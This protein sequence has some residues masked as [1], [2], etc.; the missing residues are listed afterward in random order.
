MSAPLFFMS[1]FY[2][3]PEKNPIHQ[4][5]KIYTAYQPEVDIDKTL[6]KVRGKSVC[7]IFKLQ[8]Q[9]N[10]LT[11]NLSRNVAAKGV[12]CQSK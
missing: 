11:P 6:R 8:I 9:N 10:Q 5:L 2:Q 7:I 4:R 12:Q 1:L 3:Q